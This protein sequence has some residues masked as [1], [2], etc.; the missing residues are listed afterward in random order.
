MSAESLLFQCY[1][2]YKFIGNETESVFTNQNGVQKGVYLWAVPFGDEF[3]VYYVGQTGEL[4]TEA[5]F[6]VLSESNPCSFTAL[7]RERGIINDEAI[8]PSNNPVGTY[9]IIIVG[10]VTITPPTC[11]IIG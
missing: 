8:N 4:H 10:T 2:P 1:G 3:L 5:Y 9:H 6:W 7:I 11:P